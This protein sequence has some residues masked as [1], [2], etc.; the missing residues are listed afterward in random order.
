MR[1]NTKNRRNDEKKF[2]YIIMLCALVSGCNAILG[3]H[4]I[5]CFPDVRGLE[6]VRN[7]EQ[8]ILIE[9]SIGIEIQ[10]TKYF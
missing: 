5:R 7:D 4:P 6:P 10:C 1:K 9:E 3:N 8:E 2:L